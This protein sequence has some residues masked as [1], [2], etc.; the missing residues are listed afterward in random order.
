MR[1]RSSTSSRRAVGAL[2]VLLMAACGDGV[3]SPDGVLDVSLVVPDGGS[4]LY[5]GDTVRLVATPLGLGGRPVV[6]REVRFTSSAPAVAGVDAVTGLVT[7]NGAGLARITATCDGVSATTEVRVT[8]AP[9]AAIAVTPKTRTLHPQW[10]VMLAVAISDAA[11]RPL[12]GRQ[13]Q[14][15]SSDLNVASVDAT[16]LVTARGLGTATITAT[17][18]GRSDA[19]V[20]TVTP[21]DVFK[22]VISPDVRVMSDGTILQY[23]AWAQDERGFTLSDR[24]IEWTTSDASIAVVSPNGL[25][26]ARLPG[27]VLITA[28]SGAISASL[29]LTVQP[30]IEAITVTAAKDTLREGEFGAVDVYVADVAGNRL[31]DRQVTLMSSNPAVVAVLSDGRLRA[32]G[33]GSAVVTARAEGIT[34]SAKVTVIENVVFVWL[35]PAI[36]TLPK[37]SQLQLTVTV[38]DGRGKELTGRLVT[39]ESSNPGVATVDADGVVTGISRGTTV[40]TATCEGRSGKATVGVP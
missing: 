3:L 20:V 8:L 33:V 31:V 16:G 26:S 38:L 23:H 19:V 21:A 25:V 1:M 10:T 9:V 32:M 39:F 5:V 35:S 22:V 12:S 29:P 36:L 28:K 6:G 14:F 27:G 7:A 11:G 13:V 17:S 18:E 30:H 24:P 34:A 2:A 15:A 4:E 37:E 40:I